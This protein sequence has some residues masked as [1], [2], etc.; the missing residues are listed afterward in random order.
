[1]GWHDCDLYGFLMLPGTLPDY[2]C[3]LPLTNPPG[4]PPNRAAECIIQETAGNQY[5]KQK[6]NG[7]EREAERERPRETETGRGRE[8]GRHLNFPG[9]VRQQQSIKYSL[10]ILVWVSRLDMKLWQSSIIPLRSWIHAEHHR[11]FGFNMLSSCHRCVQHLI[12][13]HE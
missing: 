10:L 9:Y 13:G 7:K 3:L 2:M 8:R 6:W 12:P 5:Q 11:S 1:M 4:S